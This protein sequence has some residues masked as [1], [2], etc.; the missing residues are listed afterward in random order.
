MNRNFNK[1]RNITRRS[2]GGRRNRSFRK[3][4]FRNNGSKIRNVHNFQPTHSS[5]TGVGFPDSYDVTLCYS[6]NLQLASNVGEQQMIYEG[7]NPW[8]PDPQLGGRSADQYSVFQQV[9][10]YCRVYG[11]KIEVDYN[12]INSDAFQAVVAPLVDN[13]SISYEMLMCLPRSKVGRIVSVGGITS[14]K[15]V[16]DVNTAAICGLG[17]LNYDIGNTFSLINADQSTAVTEPTRK[18][19]WHI[20]FQTNATQQALNGSCKVRIYYRCHFYGRKFQAVLNEVTSDGD[21]TIPTLV[22][23]DDP[24]IIDDPEEL[25]N[26]QLATDELL[27]NDV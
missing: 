1:R 19:Y 21:M 20:A 13:P 23:S 22:Q 9:Y 16:N 3:A 26:K 4:G 11:S 14:S 25:V 6:N 15:L 12:I 27:F 18:W 17:N 24:T 5:A 10:K 8:D 2:R 7:N